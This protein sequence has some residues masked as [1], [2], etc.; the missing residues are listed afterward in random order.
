[1]KK[2][3]AHHWSKVYHNGKL[4]TSQQKVYKWGHCCSQK[5]SENAY[6]H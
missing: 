4:K 2:E 5:W 3:V 6:K 1:M